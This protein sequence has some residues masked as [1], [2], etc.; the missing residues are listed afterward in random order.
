MA[1]TREQA[2]LRLH[3]LVDDFVDSAS[4]GA[5]E[6]DVGVAAIVAEVRYSTS[7]EGIEYILNQRQRPEVEYTPEAEWKHEVQFRCSDSRMWVQAGLLRDALY[8]ARHFG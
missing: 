8:I 7:P 4:R 6:F 3:A 1:T 5:D 2:R